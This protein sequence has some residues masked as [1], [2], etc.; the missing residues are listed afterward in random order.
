MNVF[1][2]LD[3]FR[4][5]GMPELGVGEVVKVDVFINYYFARWPD[6]ESA[7]VNGYDM[8]DT[9]EPLAEPTGLMGRLK[10]AMLP[11]VPVPVFSARDKVYLTTRLGDTTEKTWEVVSALNLGGRFMYFLQGESGSPIMVQ[12]TGMLLA[13]P[14][15]PERHW[16]RTEIPI[17]P[18]EPPKPPKPKKTHLYT[19]LSKEAGAWGKPSAGSKEDLVRDHLKDDTFSIVDRG[20]LLRIAQATESA[21]AAAVQSAETLTAILG[22]LRSMNNRIDAL[23]ANMMV[24]LQPAMTIG[25]Q[26]Q[27]QR[28]D[29]A[30]DK[31][32]ILLREVTP[33]GRKCPEPME[34]ELWR[35]FCDHQFVSRFLLGEHVVNGEIVN[36]DWAL[37]AMN[38]LPLPSASSKLGRA[39]A[40]WRKPQP[41]P[42]KEKLHVDPI[43]PVEPG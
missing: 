5:D 38:E 28:S 1:K 26:R 12:E 43:P 16:K 34:K 24:A 19:D 3:R 41:K 2:P 14:P 6:F 27:R 33:Q 13:K 18:P 29:A 25:L 9:Q 17:V 31:F 42:A 21:A 32:E 36:W 8:R 11:P 10:S 39:F 23:E 20:S 7:W 4:V 30:R 35:L 15:E 40:A 22:S 37:D